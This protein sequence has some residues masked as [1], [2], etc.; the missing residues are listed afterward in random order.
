MNGGFAKGLII[1]GIIG[2]SVSMMMN[3][4]IMKGRSKKRMLRN[5]RDFLRRSGSLIGDF[6]HILR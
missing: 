6:M 4:G 2:A 3:P 5:G 1:G